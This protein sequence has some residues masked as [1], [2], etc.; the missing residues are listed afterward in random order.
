MGISDELSTVL[1]IGKKYGID[2]AIDVYPHKI[3]VRHWAV[4]K[5]RYCCPN[6][7][8]SCLQ[9]AMT[10][11]E[12]KKLFDEY[13]RAFLVIGKGAGNFRDAILEMEAELY[14]KG[15]Y[16]VFALLSGVAETS[17]QG[18]Q[19]PLIASSGVDLLALIR[20]FKKNSQ[21]FKPGECPSWAILLVD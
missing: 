12:L 13:R 7:K 16:K 17:E 8:P 21:P 2:E 20:R 14:K 19:R 1:N 4:A 6:F 9:T 11:E 3:E 5:C 18:K 15:F 10:P